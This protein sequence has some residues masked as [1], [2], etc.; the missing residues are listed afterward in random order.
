MEIL[1]R[2]VFMKKIISVSIIL[3]IFTVP[4]LFP[5][6]ARAAQITA[7]GAGTVREASAD[8]A[9]IDDSALPSSYSSLDL[10]YCSTVKN[11]TGS[12]CWA[13]AAVSSFES[14][15]LK[16]KLFSLD[17]SPDHIDL[18][19]TV[20]DDANGWQRTAGEPGYT[21]IP[22]GYLTS[23]SGPVKY[24]DNRVEHSV[25][26]LEY[27]GKNDRNDA[28]RIIMES[29]AVTVNYNSIATAYSKD[30]CSFCLTDEIGVITGHTVSIVGWDDCYSRE[31]FT[32]NYHPAGD[33]AWLCKN[34][35][36]NNNS[37][38]GYFWISYED[39]YLFNDEIFG[40]SYGIREIQ[41]IGEN[42]SLYQNEEY[43]ATYEFNYIDSDRITYYNVFDFSQKGNILDKVIFESTSPGADYTLYYVPVDSQGVPVADK[44]R[45][46]KLGEGTVDY[47]GYIC[48][49]VDDVILSQ[50]KGAIAVELDTAQVNADK[51]AESKIPN[52]VGVSEWL[53]SR[54]TGQMIFKQPCR[55][56][57]SFVEYENP[58]TEAREI[59]DVRDYYIKQLNDNIGG[60]L[61]IKAAT[62]G[63]FSTK[64]PGDVDFSGEADIN[65]VTL[66]QK[67]IVR[68]VT[69][70]DD[71]R[72]T[73]ADFNGDGAIDINDATALQRFIAKV[74]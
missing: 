73:N 60:T 27:L 11:Q 68:S 67:Y 41:S 43:G 5:V 54:E 7:Y 8:K 57:D 48:C 9:V 64:T 44:S 4:L 66:I 19:G 28:K 74:S 46:T 21:Y 70:F 3:L 18:W 37:L 13:Y 20:R 35:W 12:I 53:Q 69:N 39:Y 29:G 25:N 51:E 72:L 1:S 58:N 62:N 38:G 52:G 16:N 47:R 49:D 14:L 26:A 23:R 2:G 34:S 22:I 42:D 55:Y 36:G 63:T 10:G 17:L 65:D 32:G 45:R 31:N 30:N 40:P 61:V 24:G 71:D 59:Y 50:T 33:G 15:L 6:T 56:G